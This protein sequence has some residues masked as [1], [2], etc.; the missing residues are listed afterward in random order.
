MKIKRITLSLAAMLGLTLLLG[1]CQNSGGGEPVGKNEPTVEAV[2]A[3]MGTLSNGIDYAPYLNAKDK[4]HF[5]ANAKSAGLNVKFTYQEFQSLPALNDALATG[6]VDMTLAA[7]IP[8]LVGKASGIDNKLV[9]Q[10]CTLT[11]SPIV[12]ANSKVTSV[13]QLRGKRIAVM[14]GTGVHYGLME[15]LQAA[16]LKKEDVKLIDMTPP[17]AKAAFETGQVDA[18][19]IW[20]P[21]PEELVN[22]GKAKF[23]P[24]AN[25]TV[26]VLLA[27]RSEFIN[28]HRD[29]LESVMTT[30]DDEKE[31][32]KNSP[33]EAKALT[34][35]ALSLEPAVVEKAW[36]RENWQV[37][38]DPVVVKDIQNKANFLF[39]NGMISNRV[40]VQQDFISSVSMK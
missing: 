37:T 29:V 2:E 19:I 14:Y 23:I 35:K 18:W 13:A 5:E 27:A 9:K 12:Q 30:F 8:F 32:I 6:K 28:K 33:E 7:E 15:L 40:N 11:V 20:P 25:A 3:R 34:A 4:G 38:L 22:A 39:D 36:P 1:G 17:D 26:Q 16:G 24:G 21:F 10:L 31:W